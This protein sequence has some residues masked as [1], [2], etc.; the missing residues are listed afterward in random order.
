MAFVSVRRIAK[1]RVLRKCAFC[2]R[3]VTEDAVRLFGKPDRFDPSC[4]LFYHA[5]CYSLD[6]KGYTAE[7]LESSSPYST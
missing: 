2:G 7:D 1:P 6:H 5:R 3:Y 4:T